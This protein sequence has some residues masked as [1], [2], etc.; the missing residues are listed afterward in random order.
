M[1]NENKYKDDSPISTVNK[2][3]NL[4]YTFNLIPIES[5]WKNSAEGYYSLSVSIKGT[6]LSTNGKGTSIEYALASAYGEMMERLQNQSFYRLSIDLGPEAMNYLNFFYAPDERYTSITDF[7]RKNDEWTHLQTALMNPMTNVNQMFDLWKQI[8][9]ED[10]PNDLVVIPYLNLMTKN[11][12]HIP[13]KMVSKMYMSNG[14]CAGNTIE[15]ALV[16]GLSEVFERYVNR[17]ILLEKI[18]PPT[19]PQDYLIQFPRIMEMISKIEHSGNYKVIM[20]DCS[21]GKNFP[22]VGSIF[23]NQFDQT[24]FVKFGSHP[25]IEIAMERTLTELL[26]GQDVKHMMGIK[27]YSYIPPILDVDKNIIG[28]LVNGSGY[29][30][31]EFFSKNY[32]YNFKGYSLQKKS[33]NREMLMHLLNLLLMNNYHVFIRDVSYLGFPSYHVIVPGFS[34]VEMID[35]LNT[36]D[37]YVTFVKIKKMIRNISQLTSDGIKE[38]LLLMEKN[39]IRGEAS[40]PQLLSFNIDDNISWYYRSIDLFKVAL[41]YK[42]SNYEK[43]YHLLDQYL[44]KVI[45]D[46]LNHEIYTYYKCVRDYIGTRIDHL[47]EQNSI[48]ALAY[49]YPK[50]MISDVIGSFKQPKLLFDKFGLIRCWECNNCSKIYNCSYQNLKQVNKILKDIYYSNFIDQRDMIEQLKK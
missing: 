50:E 25:Q 12:S 47:D 20:K 44:S 26:Q 17:K 4:L 37:E 9:Y 27:E 21:L 32:S 2:I 38:L 18:C 46:Q 13:V 23:V 42:I 1:F 6:Q 29:Y 36:L 33:T 35:D 8:S 7:V 39:G 48:N 34:E 16:Q 10:T 41:Y 49:F 19:I 30:P 31:S 15:E 28:I 40:I 11:I 24:Y 3:R 22:V 14:M 43:A 5:N 45:V